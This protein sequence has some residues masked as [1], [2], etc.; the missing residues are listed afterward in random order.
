MIVPLFWA[1]DA[2]V[3]VLVLP[4]PPDEHAAATMASDSTAA[5]RANLR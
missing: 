5:P 2:D 3:P 1:G 4:P